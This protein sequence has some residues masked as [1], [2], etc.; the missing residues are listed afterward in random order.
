MLGLRFF[1]CKACE[2]VF[3]GV[4]EPAVCSECDASRFD[5]VT[6]ALQHEP[7]FVLE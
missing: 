4:D 7:Y 5:E 6:G 2:T 3:A 1:T